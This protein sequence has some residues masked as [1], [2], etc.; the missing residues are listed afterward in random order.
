MLN[1]SQSISLTA[2]DFCTKR[3]NGGKIAK[4]AAEAMFWF[5]KRGIHDFL[6]DQGALDKTADSG[7][8]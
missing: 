6:E 5:L 4:R 3:K 1:I 7:K 8:L 2:K